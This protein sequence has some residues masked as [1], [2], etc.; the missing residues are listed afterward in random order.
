[1]VVFDKIEERRSAEERSEPNESK[2]QM[3]HSRDRAL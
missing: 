3:S 2:V 1:M